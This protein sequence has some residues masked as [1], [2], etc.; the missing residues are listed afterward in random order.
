MAFEEGRVVVALR[1][2]DAHHGEQEGEVGA[3][4]D[5]DPLIRFG[6]R[7]RAARIEGNHF[8]TVFPALGEAHHAAGGDGADGGVVGDEEDVTGVVEIGQDL[9]MD[10]EIAG[11]GICT[12]VA[13]GDAVLHGRGDDVGY[14][15][16]HGEG[17]RPVHVEDAGGPAAHHGPLPGFDLRVCLL[18]RDV[19]PG[20]FPA[21]A[22]EGVF[23]PL[24]ALDAD[25]RCL[26]AVGVI[27][28][29][30]ARL[31]AGAEF[32]AIQG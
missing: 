31:A 7:F 8:G 11:D 22:A 16:G 26:D 2:H 1:H 13:G 6:C 28:L 4:T 29:P 14:A 30:Q 17:H 12:Q 20:L 23:A 18:L 3:G 32:A 9:V 25:Q 15:V 10:I 27:D 5:G 21:G 24:A 19:V